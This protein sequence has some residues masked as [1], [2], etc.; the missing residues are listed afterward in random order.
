MKA[1]SLLQPWA[2]LV[3]MGL[4]TIETRS[5]TTGYRGPL[6]IHASTGR[7]GALLAAEP[8]FTRHIHSFA[9]LPFG[10][11]L[12]IVNLDEI[13]PVESLAGTG[14]SLRRLTLE[15]KA[16]GDDTAGRW[17]WILSGARAFDKPI[18]M[19]G[20]LGLWTYSGPLPDID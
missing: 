19:R 15:E 4:K 12:G 6:L 18:P 17:G 13:V 3:V 16:F 7:A 1:L 9:A 2:T 14:I 10:A 5:W 8:P 11:L 20:S